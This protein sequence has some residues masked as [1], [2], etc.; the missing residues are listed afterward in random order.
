MF[1]QLVMGRGEPLRSG[2]EAVD[3]VQAGVRGIFREDGVLGL[4]YP[5][6]P[7]VD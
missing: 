1:K 2:L 3:V 5:P 4:E 7:K 6:G